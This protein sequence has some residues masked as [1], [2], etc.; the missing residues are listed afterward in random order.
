MKKKISTDKNGEKAFKLY[1]EV[2]DH[3]HYTG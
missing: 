3:S 1:Q 2:R